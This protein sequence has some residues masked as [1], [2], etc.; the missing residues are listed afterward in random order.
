MGWAER[1]QVTLT[2]GGSFN[3]KVNFIWSVAD[4]LRGDLKQSEY[5]RVILP[6]VVLRRLDCVLAGTK[7]AVVERAQQLEGRVDNPDKALKAVAGHEFYNTSRFD[8]AELTGDPSNVRDNLKAFIGGF[9]SGARDVRA[10]EAR[11]ARQ[12]RPLGQLTVVATTD[13]LLVW[14]QNAWWSVWYSA[15]EQSSCRDRRLHLRF[16]DTPP[17]LLAGN[18]SPLANAIASARPAAVDS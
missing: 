8:F 3:D 13:R 12:W 5:G 7:D 9:S 18:V 10:A 16:L 14:H 6:L 11:A 17:Y 1:H 4:L 15:I 2:N